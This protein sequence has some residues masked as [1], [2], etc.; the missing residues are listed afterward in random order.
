MERRFIFSPK[1][2]ACRNFAGKE[3]RKHLLYLEKLQI[4]PPDS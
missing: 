2:E 1:P 4:H 3:K